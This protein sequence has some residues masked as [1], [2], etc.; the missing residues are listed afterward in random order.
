VIRA[1]SWDGG[2]RIPVLTPVPV[3]VP[4]LVLGGPL[5]SWSP[6]LRLAA[7]ASRFA[8]AQGER[9]DFLPTSRCRFRSGADRLM[10]VRTSRRGVIELVAVAVADH[11]HDRVHDHD[12]DHVNEHGPW[13]LTLSLTLT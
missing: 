12:H 13:S 11:V 7:R 9:L 10:S 3:L 5:A 8:A 1:G 4:V 2:Q 6:A